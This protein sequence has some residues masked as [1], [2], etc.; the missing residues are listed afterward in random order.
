MI[1][2]QPS[3]ERAPV[4]RAYW[5]CNSS[6]TSATVSTWSALLEHDSD[7]DWFSD[8]DEVSC[9]LLAPKFKGWPRNEVPPIFGWALS[10]R[11]LPLALLPENECATEWPIAPTE[12]VEF[13]ICIWTV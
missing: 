4:M 12:W 13:C 11:M 2:E 9:P 3:S 6:A 1:S 7:M 10:M 5:A 8:T